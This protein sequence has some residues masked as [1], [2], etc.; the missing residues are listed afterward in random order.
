MVHRQDAY[1][2]LQKLS[3]GSYKIGSKIIKVGDFDLKDA[4][5]FNHSTILL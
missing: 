4:G 1:R 3:S 5:H 2:A